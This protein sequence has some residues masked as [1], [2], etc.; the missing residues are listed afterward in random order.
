MELR[1]P[2]EHVCNDVLMMSAGLV[3]KQLFVNIFTGS[4]LQGYIYVSVVFTAVC[5]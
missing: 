4:N 2:D 1:L 3:K 5:M